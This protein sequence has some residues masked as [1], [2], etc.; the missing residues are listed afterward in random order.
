MTDSEVAE[1]HQHRDDPDEWGDEPE[2]VLVR[3]AVSE[4]VSFRLPSDEL[5][6]LQE[7]AQGRGESLSEFIRDS[8][9]MRRSAWE[10]A[11]IESVTFGHEKLTLFAAVF[12]SSLVSKSW[13]PDCPPATQNQTRREGV[14]PILNPQLSMAIH[15]IPRGDEWPDKSE[16]ADRIGKRDAQVG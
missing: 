11:T 6:W 9:R 10:P 8:I 16:D 5:D 13:V 1:L 15:G 14:L 7:T 3:P 12:S 4:V 2:D